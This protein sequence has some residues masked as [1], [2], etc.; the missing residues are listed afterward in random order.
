MSEGVKQHL[1]VICIVTI[2]AMASGAFAL[3]RVNDAA[4]SMSVETYSTLIFLIPCAAMLIGSFIIAVTA[5]TIGRQLYV[6]VLGICFVLG[7]ASLVGTS[8]GMSDPAVV[9][10]LLANSPD[11]TTITPI[12]DSPLIVM[13]NIAAYIVV[14]TIGCIA[15]AWIGSRIHPVARE[16]KGGGKKGSAGKGKRK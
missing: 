3:M 1:P 12:T 13:R 11:G 10:A 5:Q 16:G 6:V 9:S 14:P 7:L 15:G 2:V 8:V 4:A